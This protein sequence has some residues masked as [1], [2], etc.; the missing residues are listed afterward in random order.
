MKRYLMYIT[1]ILVLILVV[2]CQTTL[3]NESS[4]IGYSDLVGTW[5][6]D[7]RQYDVSLP[8]G[9]ETLILGTNGTFEQIFETTMGRRRIVTGKW[10]TEEIDDAWIRIYLVGASYYLEGILAAKSPD[11]GVEAWDP[12]LRHHVSIGN[13][14]GFVIL[15]ATR[16][17]W[18]SE[19]DSKIPCGE[20]GEIVL[21]HLPIGD[22]DA[23]T[24]VTFC[25]K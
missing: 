18:D 15:Y 24:W 13:K 9:K 11:F 4:P 19:Y 10:S 1:W 25:R 14:S 21:Q 23:P 2:A 8:R 22:L 16:L 5:T 6:A 12:V 7:Y 3:E 17:L 20:K